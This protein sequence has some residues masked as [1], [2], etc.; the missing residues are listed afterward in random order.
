MESISTLLLKSN[1][2]FTSNVTSAAIDAYCANV[3]VISA[4]N[5][6]TLNM[7]PLM[8]VE[9]VEFVNNA[10][11]FVNAVEKLKSV[12]KNKIKPEDIFWLDPSL[13]RWKEI[14]KLNTD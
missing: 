5:P 2:A 1:I 4:L 14:L 11:E 7:S 12:N 3:P 9:G 10:S 6:Q 13:S 8:G